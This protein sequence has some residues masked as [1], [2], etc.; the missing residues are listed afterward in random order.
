MSASGRG[1]PD[2]VDKA[3]TRY[4][5]EALRQKLIDD[6]VLAAVREDAGNVAGSPLDDHQANSAARFQ[7]FPD[8]DESIAHS[9]YDPQ[10][11]PAKPLARSNQGY[12]EPHVAPALSTREARRRKAYRWL[13]VLVFFP[14]AGWIATRPVAT[15]VE[16]TAIL[17]SYGAEVPVLSPVDGA[18]QRIPVQAE[19]RV[20]RGQLL[21]QIEPSISAS[22]LKAQRE[23]V[24]ARLKELSTEARL[25]GDP[26][27]AYPADLIKGFPQIDVGPLFERA[28]ERLRDSEREESETLGPAEQA[29]E[30]E[31][32]ALKKV[33][34]EKYAMEKRLNDI[35]GRRQNTAS[36]VSQNV[37][38]EDG[39]YTE[40]RLKTL[41]QTEQGISRE[42]D[43]LSDQEEQITARLRRLKEDLT[44]RQEA[45]RARLRQQLEKDRSA[46]D[47]AMKGLEHLKAQNNVV[48]LLATET[49]VFDPVPLL[50]TG[51]HVDQGDVLGVLRV[52]GNT[53]LI[54]TP[55]A[56]RE[57]QRI[58][59]GQ[60]VEVTLSALESNTE[61]SFQGRVVSLLA[62][63]PHAEGNMRQPRAQVEIDVKSDHPRAFELVPGMPGRVHIDTEGV[64]VWRFMWRKVERQIDA[65]L[66]P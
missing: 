30:S 54:E 57:A 38:F 13:F 9:D 55:V 8:T 19:S 14:L 12:L 6:A 34:V 65:W 15:E 63:S 52:P 47:E 21:A 29:I 22:V 4:R 44:Q 40:Q 48:E 5:E 31:T 35:R 45:L 43:A 23:L 18:I 37:I 66:S 11:V 64:A 41:R 10:P 53:G 1:F 32:A 62:Q 50:R 46:V 33:W 26:D 51:T 20:S 2:K 36:L 27:L 24:L 25:D 58:K 42:F 28:R 61:L 60:P 17:V 16:L 39:I 49:G 3:L 7:E 59:V 56:P